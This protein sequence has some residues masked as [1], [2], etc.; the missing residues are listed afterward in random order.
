MTH[1]GKEQSPSHFSAPHVPVEER[2][3]S[4]GHGFGGDKEIA[5]KAA[6]LYTLNA[7]KGVKLGHSRV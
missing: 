7:K 5:V 6:S 1:G 2:R 4:N 3:F